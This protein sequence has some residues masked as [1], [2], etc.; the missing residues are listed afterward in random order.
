MSGFYLNDTYHGVSR[1]SDP[2][3]WEPTRAGGAN[4]CNGDPQYTWSEDLS[5]IN[6]ENILSLKCELFCDG[7]GA[8][9]S[10][11]CEV[12]EGLG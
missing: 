3:A 4:S 5:L 7:R 9:V 10:Y 8:N 11:F 2:G 1:V 6:I 12:S